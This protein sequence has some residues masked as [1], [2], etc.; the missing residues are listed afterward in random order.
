[1]AVNIKEI[2]DF[3]AEDLSSVFRQL[4]SIAGEPEAEKKA[5]ETILKIY[6]ETRA[7]L[8]AEKGLGLTGPDS[9]AESAEQVLDWL[10]DNF[11]AEKIQKEV[12]EVSQTKMGEWFKM[13]LPGL[14]EDKLL[15]MKEV[16]VKL[17]EQL[18][19]ER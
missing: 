2:P 9:E 16:F 6:Q 18:N 19:Y 4:Y 5:E 1:M 17:N 15:K 14:G 13:T 11:E 3:G 7:R 8:A 12:M 10:V